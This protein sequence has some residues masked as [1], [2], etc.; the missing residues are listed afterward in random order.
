[1]PQNGYV[2]HANW[3]APVLEQQF[4]PYVLFG[5][6][7]QRQTLKQPSGQFPVELLSDRVLCRL[8]FEEKRR[9]TCGICHVYNT[10][11]DTYH[12]RRN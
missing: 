8:R 3:K 1:M 10:R 5:P 11:W 2:G 7:Y 6:P 9:F 12:C 4:C